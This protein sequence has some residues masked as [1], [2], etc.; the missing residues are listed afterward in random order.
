MRIVPLLPVG[1]M[2]SA[3]VF[4]A[5]EAAPRRPNILFMMSDDH[6]S[7]AISCYSS[8]INRTPNIDRLAAEGV[9]ME[10]VYATNP[11]CAP[12]RA[13]ILTGMYSHKNGVPTF[14]EISTD[15][16]TVGG[17]MRDAGYYTSFLGKWHLGRPLLIMLEHSMTK[18]QS[19][20]Q[21]GISRKSG[22][23]NTTE[24]V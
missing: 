3:S 6:A 23:G 19:M 10:R 18:K 24:E 15:I 8:R 12:S 16:K 14:N 11:I 4:A 1:M 20:E 2:A 5:S 22:R 13:S 21:M 9:R 7:N 17:Y